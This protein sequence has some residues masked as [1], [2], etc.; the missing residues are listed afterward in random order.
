[1]KLDSKQ[2]LPGS[3]GAGE[4]GEAA[5]GQQRESMDRK[6]REPRVE[7]A[8]RESENSL[9]S[10]F[11][12]IPESVFVLDEAGIVRAGNVTFAARLNRTL[13]ACLGRPVEE[14]LA[15]E[16][17]VRQR[18]WV[19]E[20]V[21][22]RQPAVHE[23]ERA[24]R[25][26]RSSIYPVLDEDQ[27]VRRIVVVAS[28][29]TEQRRSQEALL[30]QEAEFRAMF[31]FA[32]IGLAQADPVTGQLRRVNERMCEIT[33]F[34]AD[35][36]LRMRI[37]DVTHPED[38]EV[39][40]EM[41]R[42]VIRGQKTHYRREKRYVRKDHSVIWVNVNM[43]VIR[44]AQSRPL[45]TMATI[46]DIQ[47]RKRAERRAVR[48]AERT[49]FLLELHQ[50]AA[51]MSDQQL[52]DYVLGK[53]MQLTESAIGF[54][55]RM[56]ESAGSIQV[57]LWKDPTCRGP[58]E[59]LPGF[60]HQPGGSLWAECTRERKPVVDNE[61]C[62]VVG[63][64]VVP[65][66]CRSLKRLLAIP[67]VQDDRVLFILGVANKDEDY[68][69][70]DEGQI[71]IVANELHKMLVQRAAQERLRKLSGA[72]EQSPVSVVITDTA[73]A[74]EYVNPMFTRT[75]GYTLEEV[76]GQNPRV[77]SSGEKPAD[78]YADL[79][80]T[81]LEGKVWHGEFH[82]RKK[83]GELYW[84]TASI[85]PIRDALGRITHFVAVKEDV[86]K[87]R[88]L[89]AQYR[90]AQKLEAVGQLA[91]GVAHDFNN[92]LAGFMMQLQLMQ[93]N[94]ALDQETQNSLDELQREAMR[95]VGLT[96]QLLMFSRR[97]VLVVNPLDLNEVVAN[98]L[99]MLSR[100]IGENIDL[101]F[102]GKSGLPKVEADVGL[103][104]QVLMNLVVNARDAMP[105]GG[106]ITMET[107]QFQFGRDEAVSDP[108]R[109]AGL[110][111]CLTVSDTG[112][113]MDDVTQKHIF[114]PFFTTKEAGKGTGLGLATVHGI[115]AQHQGWVEVESTVGVGST[116]RVLL[117]ALA[118][119]VRPVNSVMM[120][121]PMLRGNET[122]LLV[123]DEAAVRRLT[124][125]VLR[126]LGYR[127]HE[128]ANG[129]EAM[130]VWGLH[131]GAIDLLFTDM[132]MPEGVSGLE[133]ATN[134]QGIKPSLKV[135]LSSGYSSEIFKSGVPTRTGLVY[136]PKPC[137]AKVLAAMVRNLLDTR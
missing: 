14:L 26:I 102:T 41:F 4:V 131:S 89:E 83:N 42:E 7:Q 61:P 47:E 134:L 118:E 23:D 86:T 99:K 50:R 34:A 67:V 9:R 85:S 36:M 84:E 62:S 25:W 46:E 133:L 20:V 108:L 78:D 90:Q 54:F 10:L 105:G 128:A 24:G 66:G 65:A 123:E 11:D 76:W 57:T 69:E 72:V 129:Q 100:L 51:Q 116:F 119:S 107:Q 82:N 13:E 53:A 75:T 16:A 30:R 121:L 39:D 6:D 43:T 117:P 60:P 31:D 45:S 59:A 110:F 48:D 109:R 15:M 101:T 113:G 73:G 137:E 58:G 38:R 35:E 55:H 126:E 18:E 17:G 2:E 130:R 96:R 127:V 33:G 28:D 70:I 40:G 5:T 49:K 106:R 97:S 44:D 29:I 98:L 115:V 111:V 1:V 64:V 132:V 3:T 103:L 80:R 124:S 95:A 88:Q 19:R 77:L 91:G 37:S 104:E 52:Y 92:I 32:S 122:I 79:W 21:R 56:A 114:E 87:L 125:R 74:I 93:G 71:R 63:R 8:L 112:C 120:E 22:T 81:I 135:I 68:A 94:Q 27:Q 12:A 136:L